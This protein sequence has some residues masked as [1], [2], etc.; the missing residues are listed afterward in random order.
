MAYN[1]IENQPFVSSESIA[2]QCCGESNYSQLVTPDDNVHI[3]L[4][5]FPCEEE[6]IWEI[7]E[8]GHSGYWEIGE[9]GYVCNWVA[10]PGS[11]NAI[12]SGSM[13]ASIYQITFTVSAM[14]AGTLQV[15]I[16]GGQTYTIYSAGTYTFY[17]SVFTGSNLLGIEISSSDGWMGCVDKNSIE[18]KSIPFG[19]KMAVI[20]NDGLPVAVNDNPILTGGNHITFKM[21]LSDYGLPNGCYRFGLID[22]CVNTGGQN[23]LCNSEFNGGSCWVTF[24][25]LSGWTISGGKA[26]YSEGGMVSHTLVNTGTD[27]TQG[28]AYTINWKVNSITGSARVRVT[29]GTQV[30]A[31]RTVAGDFTD[32]II[33]NDLG[34]LGDKLI[35]QCENTSIGASTASV[36]YVRISM[37]M[38]D[39]IPDDYSVRFRLSDVPDKGCWYKLEGCNGSDQFGFEFEISGFKPFV[40]MQ[41]E[42]AWVQPE[43]TG[44]IFRLNSGKTVI[45]YWDRVWKNELRLNEFPQH[46]H[47]FLS[48]LIAYDNFFVNGEKYSPTEAAYQ[49]AGAGSNPTQDASAILLIE[50]T[51]QKTRKVA[52]VT[53]QSTCAPSEEPTGKLFQ[54]GTP[55]TFQD[56]VSY[57]FNS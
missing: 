37:P 38:A 1:W 8:E 15:S 7:E 41:G 39:L 14:S 23:G 21:S 3:Q 55:F 57:D 34:V 42:L 12:Y 10:F 32:V 53:F 26:L 22:P 50:K 31:W 30:G 48:T 5:I 54:D 47:M 16:L 24:D 44:E 36:E 52:C 2:A 27:L 46:L 6:Q 9:D 13:S 29:I 35:L 51:I 43:I 4:E 49:T 19:W 56:G 11:W 25:E 45:P 20:D 33:C 28:V 40:R 17:F 18:I